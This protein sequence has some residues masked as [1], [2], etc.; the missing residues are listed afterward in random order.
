MASRGSINERVRVFLTSL[1]YLVLL[2]S[3][4]SALAVFAV[5]CSL[6]YGRKPT[7][8][9]G[10]SEGTAKN[11]LITTAKMSKSL[12]LARNIK[13]KYPQCKIYCTDS[14]YFFASKFSNCVEKSFTVEYADSKRESALNE[15]IESLLSIVADYDIDLIVPGCSIEEAKCLSILKAKLADLDLECEVLIEDQQMLNQLD[16]KDRFFDLFSSSKILRDDQL[17][18]MDVSAKMARYYAD[19]STESEVLFPFSIRF[20]KKE[21][22]I[23]FIEDNALFVDG[24]G[25]ANDGGA[26]FILK[27]IVLSNNRDEHIITLPTNKR[28]LVRSLVVNADE[29]WILQHFVKGAD[30]T[31]S[32]H[33]E[34]GDVKMY[35]DSMCCGCCVNY[36][37]AQN[38]RI[39]QWL[40]RKCK[41]FGLSGLLCFDFI[42][43]PDGRC[44]VLECNPRPHSCTLLMEDPE[45]ITSIVQRRSDRRDHGGRR[46]FDANAAGKQHVFWLF[47]EI[48]RMLGIL[49]MFPESYDLKDITDE[50]YDDSK[51]SVFV[52][53]HGYLNVNVEGLLV[54]RDGVLNV[55]DPWPVVVSHG[56]QMPLL[57][58]QQIFGGCKGWSV[59]D[60]C[61]V[62]LVCND[63]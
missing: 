5:I 55:Y 60:L 13:W 27:R 63:L 24:D 11:I 34:G 14:N 23:A 50:L 54:G 33:C 61:I 35:C 1:L 19:D 44:F 52:D 4:S 59:F 47:H 40:G 17:E 29:P 57:I 28:H 18:G 58:I 2:L 30:V 12:H 45:W 25:D 42:E 56:V 7:K 41:E 22:L 3:Y 10:R 38:E 37:P 51:P 48:L 53:V 9:S 16:D 32:I 31:A 20:E 26:R 21:K 6:C 36:F 46:L 49:N 8:S 15:F 39:R 43:A 62:K